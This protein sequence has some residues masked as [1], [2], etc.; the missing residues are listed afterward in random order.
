MVYLLWPEF[1]LAAYQCV[2]NVTFRTVKATYDELTVEG[3][4]SGI[5][6]VQ[7]VPAM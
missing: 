4:T 3:S 6:E 1:H 5:D 2:I 7:V